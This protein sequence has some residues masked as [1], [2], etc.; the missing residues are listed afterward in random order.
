MALAGSA[1]AVGVAATQAHPTSRTRTAITRAK[2][3]RRH[4]ARAHADHERN[5]SR[6]NRVFPTQAIHVRRF[7]AT[8]ARAEGRR[9]T[10][11]YRKQAKSVR[12]RRRN[13]R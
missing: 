12:K 10:K 8:A 13:R 11:G 6:R 9:L 4:V 1:V 3:V 5:V 7:N 2:I